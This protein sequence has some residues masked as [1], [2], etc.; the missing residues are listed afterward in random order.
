MTST[1][2][3]LT[4]N[5]WLIG[6][7]VVLIALVLYLIVAFIFYFVAK[8]KYKKVEVELKKLNDF[9]VHKGEVLLSMVDS[10]LEHNC[11]FDEESIELVRTGVKDIDSLTSEGRSR[12]IAVIEFLLVYLSK[13]KKEDKTRSKFIN[14]E[15]LDELKHLKD[16]SNETYKAYNKVAT[17]YNVFSNMVGVHFVG[18]LMRRK[19]ENAIIF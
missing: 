19:L 14:K 18:K 7:I 3:L 12:Y 11:S 10:L 5:P 1:F 4:M 16:I 9:D 15:K 17:T 2:V 8:K 6:L 13:I